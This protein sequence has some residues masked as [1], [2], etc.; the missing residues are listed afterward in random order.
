MADPIPA[1]YHTIT[2]YIVVKDAPAAIEFYKNA[3][4]AVE[5]MRLTGPDGKLAH[6][7]VHIGDSIVMLADEH[8]DMGAV[9]PDTSRGASFSLMIYTEQPD[10]MFETALSAG[11]EVLRPMVD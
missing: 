1:D 7:E 3:F 11:A 6:A 4:G 8:P 9:G 10:E 5:K 2:P